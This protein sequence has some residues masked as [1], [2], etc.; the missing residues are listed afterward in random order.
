MLKLIFFIVSIIPLGVSVYLFLRH[1]KLKNNA[2]Y[3][4]GKILKTISKVTHSFGEKRTDYFPIISFTDV[5]GVK[6]ELQADVGELD[7][8]NI[9]V[10]SYVDIIYQKDNPENFVT[11]DN[12]NLFFPALAFILFLAFI[13]IAMFI[14]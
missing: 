13:T 5:R 4:K 2:I 11:K 10:D 6:H 1:K 9:L 12:F 14:K 7:E 8:K 3:T